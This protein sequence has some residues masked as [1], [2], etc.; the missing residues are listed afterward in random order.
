MA[1]L[2]TPN[3]PEAARLLDEPVA[4]SAESLVEQARRLSDRARCAVLLKGGHA[5]SDTVTDILCHGDTI[6]RLDGA[7]QR[8]TLRGTGCALSTAIALHLARSLALEDACREAKH[9]VAS[10][11]RGS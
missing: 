9:Y 1:T 3:I 5:T 10:L 6:V 11:I 7:R 8:G 4:T 2:L